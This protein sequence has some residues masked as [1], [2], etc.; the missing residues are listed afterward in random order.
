M[1]E[2]KETT[3]E[4]EEAALKAYEEI[5]SLISKMTSLSLP[6]EAPKG[7]DGSKTNPLSQVFSYLIQEN[8]I[9]IGLADGDFS[10]N[11]RLFVEHFAIRS[12]T[13][14][15]DLFGNVKGKA[16]SWDDFFALSGSQ[17]TQITD[18]V[19]SGMNPIAQAFFA[20]I[21]LSDSHNGDKVY[22]KGFT[23]GL[24]KIVNSFLA[25]DL[26]RTNIENQRALDVISDNILRPLDS[27]FSN[28]EEVI[29][30]EETVDRRA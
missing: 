3:E 10:I 7:L 2:I 19:K 21:A 24:A 17:I 4:Y 9:E 28:M 8:L 23:E 26:A 30:D 20:A 25:V 27:A 14:I 22:Y 1:K 15:L 5:D 16:F 11:E 12:G 13:S 18:L 6:L 29:D